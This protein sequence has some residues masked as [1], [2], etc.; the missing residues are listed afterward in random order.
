MERPKDVGLGPSVSFKGPEGRG[1]QDGSAYQQRAIAVP[2][3]I[4]AETNAM[5]YTTHDE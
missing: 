2:W 3:D 5:Q 1:D 4:Y